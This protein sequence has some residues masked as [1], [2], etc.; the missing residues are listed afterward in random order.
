M[1]SLEPEDDPVAL[2]VWTISELTAIAFAVTR[3]TDVTLETIFGSAGGVDIAVG[4][5]GV[6]AAV[7]LLGTWTNFEI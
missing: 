2:S 6:V 7:S 4:I 1:A 3:W 5:G